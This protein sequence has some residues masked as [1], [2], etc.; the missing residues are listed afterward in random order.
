MRR[1]RLPLAVQA[2]IRAMHPDLRR[3]VREALDVI[4]ASPEAGKPLKRELSG[5]RSFRIGRIRIVY[6]ETRT[7]LEIGAI[8][9]RTSIYQDAARRLPKP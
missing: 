5:W 1:V 6:R 4:R 9:P 7:I 3:R 8:G 2:A